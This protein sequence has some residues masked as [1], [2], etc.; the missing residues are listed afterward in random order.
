GEPRSG[1]LVLDSNPEMVAQHWS[2]GWAQSTSAIEIPADAVLPTLSYWLRLELYSGDQLRFLAR[3]EGTSDWIELGR[4]G[5]GQNHGVRYE[6][7]SLSLDDFIGKRVELRIEQTNGGA[8]GDRR[9]RI[10]DLSVADF[11]LPF[12]DLGYPYSS[13]F[14]S[15][16]EQSHWSLL[17]DFGYAGA[18]HNDDGLYQPHSGDTYL[19]NNFAGI[20]GSWRSGEARQLGW[21]DIPADAQEPT[22]SFWLRLEYEA[23]SSDAFVR[24][25]RQG[26]RSWETLWTLRGNHRHGDWR[27]LDLDLSAYQGQRIRLAF[28]H[29]HTG[30]TGARRMLVDDISVGPYQPS[31]Q[32]DY[33]YEA[34]FQQAQSVHDEDS[35]PANDIN[36]REDWQSVNTWGFAR[37]GEGAEGPYELANNPTEGGLAWNTSEI[38]LDGYIPIPADAQLPVIEFNYRGELGHW[39]DRIY[40]EAKA[41]GEQDWQALVAL[42][43]TYNRTDDARAEIDLSSYRGKAIRLRWRQAF[44]G[45]NHTRNFRFSALR[46]GERN[47]RDL[48]YPYSQDFSDGEAHWLLEGRWRF[49]GEGEAR[50]MDSN[51]DGGEVNPNPLGARMDGVVHIPADAVRPTLSFDY[52]NQMLN[53]QDRARVEIQAGADP[54]WIQLGAFS[55][56]SDRLDRASRAEF[57][58]T[59]Y[60]GQP[61]RL[62][63]RY[64]DGYG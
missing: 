18:A 63:F 4:Y 21:M 40:L 3:E 16:E 17:A 23:W 44:P 47:D 11:A 2:A 57:D 56:G 52:R 45:G 37:A 46:V 42:S 10:D 8:R 31:H 9:A 43:S 29:S 12:G 39:A 60:A 54:S 14:E 30:A 58:L 24:V 27:R 36:A 61:I 28:A 51:V 48:G 33:P 20:L 26:S 6:R 19:D 22:L 62:R 1:G 15:A 34:H 53:H 7:H 41:Q 64:T 5:A 50:A 35:D 49:A 59:P 32:L 25:Q 55:K 38:S 13:G